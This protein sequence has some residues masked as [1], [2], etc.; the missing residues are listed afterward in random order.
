MD[1]VLVRTDRLKRRTLPCRMLRSFFPIMLA[2][3]FLGSA[4]SIASAQEPV[5]GDGEFGPSLRIKGFA[6]VNY[7][8]NE[9][10]SGIKEGQNTF[11]LGQVDLFITSELSPKSSFLSEIVFEGDAETNESE[12]DLERVVLE[13][14]LNSLIRLK[15]GRMHTAISYWNTEYHHGKWFQTTAFRPIFYGWEEDRGLLPIHMVGVYLH[16]KKE[17][18][19]LDISYGLGLV[20]GRG[21]TR[22]EIQSFQDS[23]DFKAVNGRFQISSNRLPGLLLGFNG[24]IDRIPEN[25]LVPKGKFVPDP[26]REG[27]IKEAIWGGYVVYNPSILE[28]INEYTLIIHDDEVSDK[29][30][31]SI[32]YYFQLSLQKGKFRPYYRFEYS[33]IDESD[34]YWTDLRP[35]FDDYTANTVGLK[36]DLHTWTT[37]KIEY[38]F[39]NYHGFENSNDLYVQSAFTF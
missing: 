15:I 8:A 26:A 36:W 37:L 31:E 6:D 17:A 39:N 29:K 21:R 30:Y 3:F 38:R 20:N 34:P 28:I 33:D 32:G 10:I 23:N 1:V 9:D 2:G 11:S 27:E 16:G 5:G 24:Y 35:L 18:D 22:T 4:L 14:S 7:I 13:Y 12:V 25:D 19:L